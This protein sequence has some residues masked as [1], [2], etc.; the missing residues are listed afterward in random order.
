MRRAQTSGVS[1]RSAVLARKKKPS[2]VKWKGNKPGRKQG[3]KIELIAL[4]PGGNGGQIRKGRMEHDIDWTLDTG[5][6]VCVAALFAA[7]KEDE[8]DEDDSD[9]EYIVGEDEEDKFDED[10]SDSED[11]DE[12][13]LLDM[14]GNRILPVKKLFDAVTENMCC[15]KCAA[16][17]HSKFVS[18][19]LSF[20]RKYE[21]T[22]SEAEGQLYFGS[23][24][25][26]YEWRLQHRLSVGELYQK[27]TGTN[28]S[29]SSEQR[30]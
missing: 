10:N 14:V 25:E 23:K 4:T 5:S 29:M 2:A 21:S 7:D 3:S 15:K 27:F 8:F 19:F 13:C 1:T 18:Q 12:E 17:E 20:S 22:V 16:R 28:N 6:P 24:L 30:V 9:S 11:E 26:R